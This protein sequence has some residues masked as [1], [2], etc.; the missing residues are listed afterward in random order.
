MI[1]LLP[2]Q[3]PPTSTGCE[4]SCNPPSHIQSN[5]IYCRDYRDDEALENLLHMLVKN[6]KARILV[7]ELI[8]PSFITSAENPTA[9]ASESLPSSQ[10]GYPE[11]CHM[12][13]LNT[14][15]NFINCV[16]SPGL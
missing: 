15:L 5:K 3:L 13:Q 1:T 9:P 12:M 4:A 16:C 8:I 7:N 11:M 10:S 6:P 14:N 2:K